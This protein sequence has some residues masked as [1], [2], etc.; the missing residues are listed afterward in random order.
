MA[1]VPLPVALR[2]RMRDD[3]RA[4]ASEAGV[5]LSWMPRGHD[6]WA[7]E[8]FPTCSPPIVLVPRIRKGIDY[9]IG[10]HEIGHCADATALLYADEPGRSA[11]V[12]CEAGAWAWAIERADRRLLAK[13]T[14]RDWAL[15]A[16]ALG[17]HVRAAALSQP[18]SHGPVRH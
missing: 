2:R 1:A 13:L 15:V 11:H 4:R 17:S 12:L 18:G 9:L 10:L 5:Q 6:R 3:V 14:H 7:A 16:S 8:S